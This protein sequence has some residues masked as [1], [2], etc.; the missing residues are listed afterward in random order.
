MLAAGGTV[1]VSQLAVVSADS[2][3]DHHAF[4]LA[5]SLRD[6]G[7]SVDLPTAGNMG[8]KM[9]KLDK[10]GIKIAIILGGDEVERGVVQ[11]RNLAD[12]SQDEVTRDALIKALSLII[13]PT[14]NF[15]E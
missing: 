14:D 10:A 11:L 5:E 13:A 12:G 9:K 2:K 6:A 3:S 15:N 7:F 4:Q 8:K 1:V